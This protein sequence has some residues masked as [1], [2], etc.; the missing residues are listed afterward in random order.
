MF[1]FG[2]PKN[3]VE[4]NRCV[5]YAGNSFKVWH[6]SPWMPSGLRILFAVSGAIW[7]V[8]QKHFMTRTA[9]IYSLGA[10]VFFRLKIQGLGLDGS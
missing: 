2:T 6:D 3:L 4:T 5:I 7:K 10:H 1:S 9:N 8:V